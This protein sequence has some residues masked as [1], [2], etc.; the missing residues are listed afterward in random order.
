MRR[1]ILFI[2]L[3]AWLPL[4]VLSIVDGTAIGEVVAVPFLFDF[5]AQVRFLV[6]LP[7][8]IGA[9]RIVHQR[10]QIVVGQFTSQGLV[11]EEIRPHFDA[12]L[13]SAQSCATP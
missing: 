13:E 4:L 12:A 5:D 7:L 10:M 2:A 8:L 11:T 6:A 9:E 1:R 3:F